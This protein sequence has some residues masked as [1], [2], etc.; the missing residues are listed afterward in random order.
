MAKKVKTIL[1]D[2]IDSSDAA[3]TVAFS[4]DNVNYEIDLNAAHAKEL[5]D[6]LQRWID[7]GRK[8]SGRRRRGTTP[9]VNNEV[10]E[11]NRRVRAWAGE[12]GI[13]VNDRGRV[14]QK[15][16]D[17]YRDATGDK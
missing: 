8:V 11:L 1:I 7:A 4:L 17:Q 10:R 16:I 13:P 9:A 2:D 15:L 6:S 12:K 3:E 5:R 14:P